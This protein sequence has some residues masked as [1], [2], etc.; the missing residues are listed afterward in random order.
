MGNMSTTMAF[1]IINDEIKAVLYNE[2]ISI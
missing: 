1:A 2:R